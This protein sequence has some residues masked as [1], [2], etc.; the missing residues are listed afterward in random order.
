M[1]VPDL[2]NYR[3]NGIIN[4]MRFLRKL[5]H[6][7]SGEAHLVRKKSRHFLKPLLRSIL[8]RGAK[9]KALIFVSIIVAF[10]VYNGVLYYFDQSP[11][12]SPRQASPQWAEETGEGVTFPACSSSSN[13][14]PTCSGSTPQVSLTW[15]IVTHACTSGDLRIFANPGTVLQSLES[16]SAFW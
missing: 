15:N 9:E 16:G 2:G 7:I 8:S 10:G 11:L 1:L 14:A 13:T 6:L 3:R 5:R 12:H 4:L